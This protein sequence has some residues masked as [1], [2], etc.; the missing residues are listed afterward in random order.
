MPAWCKIETA[1]IYSSI[2]ALPREIFFANYCRVRDG[3]LMGGGLNCP[4]PE[5]FVLRFHEPPIVD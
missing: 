5:P 3:W 4:L 2:L 1:Y